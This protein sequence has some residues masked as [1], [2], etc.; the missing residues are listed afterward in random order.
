MRSR[1]SYGYICERVVNGCV[2]VPVLLP[3]PPPI[4]PRPLCSLRRFVFFFL[5]LSKSTI[6]T[7]KTPL[8]LFVVVGAH[9]FVSRASA[10][11]S[12]LGCVSASFFFPRVC[13][14]LCVSPFTLFFLLPL[15][16]LF[17]P[18]ASA[19]ARPLTLPLS[20]SLSERPSLFRFVCLCAAVRARVGSSPLSLVCL[21][22]FLQ[23]YR[24]SSVGSLSFFFADV[25][26]S[27]LP[28]IWISVSCSV[29]V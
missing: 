29:R 20:L 28:L 23:C 14:C 26:K 3:L 9:T 12:L 7:T 16:C 1:S 6:S 24:P 27:L 22:F 18:M 8:S 25:R 4:H 15:L 2:H 17:F 21:F 11:L 5:S 13:L 19:S 10:V